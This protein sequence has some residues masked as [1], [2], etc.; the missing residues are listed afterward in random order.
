MFLAYCVLPTRNVT[1]TSFA[2]RHGCRVYICISKGGYRNVSC[3][4][5]TTCK[6]HLPRELTSK[7]TTE[8]AC[9]STS[10]RLHKERYCRNDVTSELKYMKTLLSGPN[11]MK[12]Y[13]RIDVTDEAVINEF[14]CKNRFAKGFRP[15]SD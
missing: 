10:R 5:N 4:E 11:K 6:E 12:R 2:L 3:R 15:H 13:R 14:N 1:V 9:K 7:V 8:F